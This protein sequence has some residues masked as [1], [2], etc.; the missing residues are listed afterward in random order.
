MKSNPLNSEVIEYKPTKS[1]EFNY[2]INIS[3]NQSKIFSL[4]HEKTMIR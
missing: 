4:L 1:R 2:C 3:P